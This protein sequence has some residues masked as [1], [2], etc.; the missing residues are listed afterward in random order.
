VEEV[1]LTYLILAVGGTLAGTGLLAALLIAMT[2]WLSRRAARDAAELSA[3]W[4][5]VAQSLGLAVQPQ[6]RRPPILA[7]TYRGRPLR[8]V[9][10]YG[11][12]HS[13]GH[14]AVTLTTDFRADVYLRKSRGRTVGVEHLPSGDAELDRRFAFQCRPLELLPRAAADPA[15]R[16]ALGATDAWLILTPQAA[17]S[18][19]VGVESDPARLR[20]MIEQAAEAADLVEREIG[21]SLPVGQPPAAETYDDLNQ[22]LTIRVPRWAWPIVLV[23]GLGLLGGCLCIASWPAL[24]EIWRP[25]LGG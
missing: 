17:V 24:S 4:T 5:A 18:Q 16:R 11:N 13:S 19:A 9:G 1:N 25:F 6:G 14:T 20:A 12:R 23:L 8:V 15:L 2:V 7:G 3:N 10:R 22:S 21:V